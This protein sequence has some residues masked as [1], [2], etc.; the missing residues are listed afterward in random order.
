M[1]RTALYSGSFDPLTNGHLNIIE[2]ASTL[3]DSLTVAV[4]ESASKKTMFSLDERVHLVKEAVAHIP[5]VEVTSCSGLLADY[6]NENKFSAVVRGLRSASDFD[7]EIQMA[8]MNAKLFENAE[9]VFLM[10]EPKNSYISSSLTKEVASLGGDIT[11]L[12]PAN[13]LAAVRKKLV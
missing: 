5:N 10:T 4:V 2:R 11:E 12:V 6:V 8:Q 1:N 13:V 9:T 7:Y 3:F